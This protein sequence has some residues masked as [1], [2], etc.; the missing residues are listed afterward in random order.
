MSLLDW[1]KPKPKV[2]LGQQMQ[3][4]T[5]TARFNP[6]WRNTYLAKVQPDAG[7]ARVFAY[8]NLGLVE[9]APIGPADHN[10]KQFLPLQPRQVYAPQT[11]LTSGI[12]G[13]QAGQ[14]I[15]QPLINSDNM[16]LG[17][18]VV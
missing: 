7:G 10:R 6:E 3:L 9:F 13:L 8:Q 12:G 1:L 14:I 15:G 4:P 11:G 2:V 16:P 18:P 5:P 17:G